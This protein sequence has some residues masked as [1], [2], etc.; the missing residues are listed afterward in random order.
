MTTK[1]RLALGTTVAVLVICTMVSIPACSQ[2]GPCLASSARS[3]LWG[4]SIRAGMLLVIVATWLTW[5]ARLCHL[6][7]KTRYLV[8]R[9]PIR[10][11]PVEL[12]EAID[13]TGAAR[14]V[15]VDTDT[16]LAFCCG[17]VRPMIYLSGGLVQRLRPCELDAV[18]LHEM[19]HS[20]RRDPLRYAIAVALKDVCFY[21]PLLG[22]FAHYQRENAELRADRVVM[23]ILG[24]R[25]LAGA[26]WALSDAPA[27]VLV[28]AFHGA[29]ELRAAQILGDSM[30]VR[31]PA[32]TLW[33][34]SAAGVLSLLM[35]ANCLA[36]IVFLR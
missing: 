14:A 26:L 18:L 24:P 23:E 20:R 29:A 8:R 9:L 32:A 6:L 25:P 35:T 22:W 13:R 15:C 27:P 17:A 12:Q 4:S 31:R 3:E 21:I 2:F 36:Q 19:H 10:T 30:P 16:E 1:S 5:F 7:L 33:L 28:A 11:H 34:A